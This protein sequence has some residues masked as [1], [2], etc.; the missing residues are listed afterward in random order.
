MGKQKLALVSEEEVRERA[1]QAIISFV[2]D[3]YWSGK[4]TTQKDILKVFKERPYSLS[5]GTISNYLTDLISK[6]KIS[7]SYKDGHRYYTPPKIP[8]PIKFG[9]AISLSIITVF[10]FLNQILS[11]DI[12]AK[13]YFTEIHSNPSH[14]TL[15]PIMIFLL[16]GFVITSVVW[17]MAEREKTKRI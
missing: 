8:L 14:I 6:R 1:K 16:F 2:E 7:T 12:I 13:F 11:E 4:E 3:R 17:Y 5:Q 9:I 10:T 15:F